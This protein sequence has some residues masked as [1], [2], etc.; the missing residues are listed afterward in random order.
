MPVYTCFFTLSWYCCYKCYHYFFNY[1]FG[2]FLLVTD[3]LGVTNPL[4]ISHLDSKVWNIR[5][6]ITNPF[7]IVRCKIYMYALQTH[8]L[9]V[10][11]TVRSKIYMSALQTH[12]LSVIW[13][14]RSKI[15]TSYFDWAFAV[16]LSFYGLFYIAI[17]SV[18]S[19][20]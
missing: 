15:T 5:V 19:K 18:C 14:V 13:T 1:P 9:S 8:Y 16:Y 3:W 17:I 4:S 20:V 10:I 2:Q 6:C 12:Y 7:S 11:W